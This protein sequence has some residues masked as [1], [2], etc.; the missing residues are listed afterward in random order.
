MA[1]KNFLIFLFLI[2]LL[3]FALKIF[4][5]SSIPP[6][7]TYDELVYV[8]ESQVI[9]E[10]GTDVSGDWRPWHLS[11]SK[12]LY[13]ELTST[14]L[15]PGFL[16]FPNNPF[17]ASKIVPVLMGSAIP[18]LL[19]LIVFYFFKNKTYL[20][21]VAFVATL[22]P[23]V[24]QFSRMGFDSLFSIFF[25]LLGIVL[26]LYLTQWWKLLAT[27]PFF[28]GFFQYQ[29]HKT[30]LI[31]LIGLIYL[32]LLIEKFVEYKKDKFVDKLKKIFT[33]TLAVLLV[34]I[35]AFLL[36]S[37]YL[38]RL[39]TMSSAVRSEEFS[40]I[41]QEALANMVIEKRRLAFDSPLARIFDNK[42]T[43]YVTLLYRALLKSFDPYLLFLRGDLA[44]DTFAVSSHGFFHRIDIVLILLFFILIT[45]SV[46]NASLIL[47]FLLS[48]TMIG[49]F[50]N[51]IK[52]QES[53]IT[54]R[55]SFA[56]LGLVMMAGVGLGLLANQLKTKRRRVFL[57]LF[58]LLFASSFFYTY[59][60]RYPITQTL[61]KGFYQRVLANYIDRNP[62]KDFVL[63]TDLTTA[64]YDYL[65]T[66]NQ[67]LKTEPESMINKFA[68]ESNKKI[69]KGRIRIFESC[70]ENLNTTVD[71]N[72]IL[73]VDWLKEP[74]SL[75]RKTANN[76]K[77][78]SLID[79]GTHF[80]IYDDQ[81]CSEFLLQPYIN[82]KQNYLALEKLD[83]ETFCTSFL[84]S[85]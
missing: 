46:K 36:T 59:F 37:N 18:V 12:P 31:P 2:F 24:F 58:Y 83:A 82:L 16:L 32:I 80:S 35:F 68:Q 52:T 19:A 47:F 74:C 56:F 4:K 20:L 63:V 64:T 76:I 48:F 39:K 62:D 27:I 14:T 25:Y 22:N 50:P 38:S 11:P 75:E 9:L 40:L 55:G 8:A 45:K 79:G 71:E 13:S 67:Y 69:D 17:L 57:V 85:R 65:L 3:N 34:L 53:W 21:S 84:I 44:V 41:D 7:L 43:A 29:G 72:T 60:F 5:I 28:W 81:L 33:K 54:F 1:K 49:A 51:L 26:L 42:L 61:H 15:I 73:I 66:Y 30:I 23:W 6:G 10:H 78:V 70:P 77:I